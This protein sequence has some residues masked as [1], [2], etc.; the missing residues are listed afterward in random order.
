VITAQESVLTWG[1]KSPGAD[2]ELRHEAHAMVGQLEANNEAVITLDAAVTPT[3]PIIMLEPAPGQRLWVVDHLLPNGKQREIRFV[4][5]TGPTAALIGSFPNRYMTPF[6]AIAISPT[7]V[8]LT[9]GLFDRDEQVVVSL[10]VR[11]HLTCTADV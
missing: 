1:A 10:L 5:H 9:G 2:G 11:A 8:L 3:H 4:G 7:E 6:R